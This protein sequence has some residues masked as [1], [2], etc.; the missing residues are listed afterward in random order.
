METCP[1]H[2]VAY[3]GYVAP[4]PGC[5]RPR[6][7]LLVLSA[8]PRDFMCPV[9]YHRLLA[10]FLAH[11]RAIFFKFCAFGCARRGSPESEWVEGD[12][13]RPTR[14]EYRRDDRRRGMGL[15]HVPE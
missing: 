14:L 8:A 10:L 12:A 3:I 1:S 13:T 4:L 9:D 11:P 5:I 6:Q 2:V 15:G 7:H